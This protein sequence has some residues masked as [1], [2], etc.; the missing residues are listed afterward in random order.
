MSQATASEVTTPDG[1]RLLDEAAVIPVLAEI[2]AIAQRLGGDPAGW[3]AETLQGGNVNQ[4]YAVAGPAGS[5]CTKQSMPYMRLLGPAAPL[6]LNRIVFEQRT[7]AEHAR[8]VP[9]RVPEIYHFDPTLHLLVMEH[10]SGHRELR[11]LLIDNE[12]PSHAAADVGEYMANTL[13][14][15][16]ALALS[17]ADCRRLSASMAG[18]SG[19]TKLME[20]F[21]FVEPYMDHPHNRWNAPHLDEVVAQFRRDRALK[22]A[23]GRLKRRY[24]GAG[25]AL[26]HGD[27]HTGSFLVGGGDTRVIDFEL[28]HYGPMGFDVGLLISHAF[29]NFFGQD[30]MPDRRDER[31][32]G[33]QWTLRFV[34]EVWQQFAAQF[35]VLWNTQRSGDAYPL[36][37]FGN[38]T[39]AAE[40]AL[41]DVLG[42]ILTDAIGFAGTEMI[43]RIIGLGQVPDLEQ[44]D[45]PAMKSRFELRCLHFARDLVLSAS[46]FEDVGAVCRAAEAAR[47]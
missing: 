18:N 31:R 27:L 30:G 6:P 21:T 17:A 3:S 37:W 11:D 24:L 14:C 16:S 13:F 8:H 34:A 28:S 44:I 2:P 47:A 36:G 4:I 39:D 10:L 42:G 32:F 25:E 1:Y 23:V 19:M 35:A 33:Q 43:R 12:Q 46:R 20:D 7:L 38:D 9:S 29:I 40:A 5:V 22:L 41:D 15:T 45:D 26:V